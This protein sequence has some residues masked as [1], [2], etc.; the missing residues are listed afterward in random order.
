MAPKTGY[1]SKVRGSSVWRAPRAP[2]ARHTRGVARRDTQVALIYVL[3][4]AD[5]MINSTA[6]HSDVP[7]APQWTAMTFIGAQLLIQ[8]LNCMLLF[9]LFFGTYLFQV[10]LIGVLMK[11]FRVVLYV[12]PLH[13]AVYVAYAGIK[14]V[15]VDVR[16][17]RLPSR[18][19]ARGCCS[20]APRRAAAAL[21]HHGARLLLSRTAARGCCSPAPRRAASALPHRGAH[22]RDDTRRRPPPQAFTMG[23]WLSPESLWGNSLFVTFSMLQKLTAAAYY[24][25]VLRATLR[26]GEAQWYQR[27]PWV[28]RF[29]ALPPAA[30]LAIGGDGGAGFA[31]PAPTV[32]HRIA[33]S[34]HVGPTATAVAVGP[35]ATG[36]GATPA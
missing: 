13:A 22:P 29:A 16:G 33:S 6:D 27:G 36:G 17:A 23:L 12:M 31:A 3:T 1:L 24:L 28:T 9:L 25:A 5:L 35:P 8:L 10:G 19:T 32:S 30:A 20:P 14:G 34:A 18:A 4:A 15:R 26:L 11:E 2:A 21:P 7:D